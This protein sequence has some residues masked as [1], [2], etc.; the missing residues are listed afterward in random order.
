M[1]NTEKFTLI[2]VEFNGQRVAD[3]IEGAACRECGGPAYVRGGGVCELHAF[4]CSMPKIPLP[5]V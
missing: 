1:T 3:A 4:D 2:S 5:R